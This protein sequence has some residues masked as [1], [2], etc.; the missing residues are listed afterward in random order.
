MI[1]LALS[2]L[3]NLLQVPANVAYFMNT[4]CDLIVQ[5]FTNSTFPKIRILSTSILCYLKEKVD[6]CYLELSEKDVKIIIDMV[7]SS[8][9]DPTAF[10]RSIT[11]IKTMHVIVKSSELNAQKFISQG[12]LSAISQI[13]SFDDFNVQEEILL[14]LW[15]LASHPNLV[16]NIKHED[17]LIKSAES[18]KV[19]GIHNLATASMCALWDIEEQEKG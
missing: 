5:N 11:L 6:E 4:V 1:Q 2:I 8:L 17:S 18:F 15:T 7:L 16:N 3:C 10:L 14:L 9:S 12:L 13:L 19:S